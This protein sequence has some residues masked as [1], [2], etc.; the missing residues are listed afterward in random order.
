MQ[1]FF[2]L[3][4]KH[5]RHRSGGVFYTGR[6]AFRGTSDIYIL[7][8]NPGGDPED[9]SCGTISA[10]MNASLTRSSD[11]WSEYADEA[12]KSGYAAGEMPHQKRVCHLAKELGLSI[13]D[14]PASNVVFVRTSNESSLKKEKEALLQACWP[15]HEAVIGRLGIK[16]ILCFGKTA[17]EWVRKRTCADQQIG[18][19]TE[20]NGRKW[21]S[22]AYRSGAGIKVISLSHPSIADWC[23]L[24]T[25]PTAFIR[26]VISRG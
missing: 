8:L 7:G 6:S 2:D 10:H 4:P 21:Q 26:A 9:P 19:F 15:V 1:E 24:P 17:G 18:S 3:V 13:R 12:W 5:L 20:A 25:D 16:A 11:V 22:V 14:I 23:S